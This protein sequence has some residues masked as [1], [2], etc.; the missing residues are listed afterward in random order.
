M[1]PPYIHKKCLYLH[2]DN[3]TAHT[4]TFYFFFAGIVRHI[5]KMSHKVWRMYEDFL[6]SNKNYKRTV[7]SESCYPNNVPY[8]LFNLCIYLCEIHE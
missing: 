8:L 4:Q 6:V 3:Y 7:Q 1:W 2:N 5:H